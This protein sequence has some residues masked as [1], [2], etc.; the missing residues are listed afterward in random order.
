MP[1]QLSRDP[2]ARTTLMREKVEPC[3][4]YS[5]GLTAKKHSFKYWRESDSG[6]A[7]RIRDL[8]PFCGVGCF[9]DYYC[10]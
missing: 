9:R 4:C 1:T 10:E 7:P 6:K 8:L 3:K 2:F 5:C